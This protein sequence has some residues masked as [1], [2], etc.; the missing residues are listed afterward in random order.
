M[1]QRLEREPFDYQVE[2]SN[3]AWLDHQARTLVTGSLIAW[4]K[5]DRVL[6]PAC[7][8]GSIVL[9]SMKHHN[10]RRVLLSDVSIPSISRMIDGGLPAQV[11]AKVA[12]IDETLAT[13]EQF[14]V[15]VLTEILEHIYDPVAV[16]SR[17]KEKAQ[18]L[19]ASSPEMR[20]GQDD[21]NPE[22]LWQFD[23]DGYQQMLEEAGWG[24]IH[25]THMGFPSLEYDFQIWV[26]K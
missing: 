12:D 22:H 17:A 15:I 24:P 23:G 8:D 19:V 9:A 3:D 4:A 26:C 16:L 2:R 21:P 1:R 14:D 18:L 6:D 25:K 11:E 5:P 7:G 20:P 10:P 13:N